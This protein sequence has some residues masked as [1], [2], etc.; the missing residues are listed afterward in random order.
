VGHVGWWRQY[1]KLV[2][3]EI[4]QRLAAGQRPSF[5]RGGL[6]GERGDRDYRRVESPAKGKG[7]GKA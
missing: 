2:V 3:K 5:S 4:D 7:G 6:E 1:E